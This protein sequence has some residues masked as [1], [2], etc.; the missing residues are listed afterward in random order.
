VI[1]E[2]LRKIEEL[3]TRVHAFAWLD[4]ER[5]R[6]AAAE[7]REGA[8]SGLL[9]GIKDIIDTAGIPTEHGSHLF[10]G[11]VPRRSATVVQ[12]IEAAGGIVAGKTVTAEMAYFTPGPTRNPWD[13][14]RTPGGSSM[15]SA[16]AVAAGMLDLAVGTQTNGSIIRP[17]A[18]CGTIGYKPS[19]G[20]VPRDGVMTFSESLDTV[21]GFATTVADAARLVA[22]MANRDLMPRPVVRPRLAVAVTP[23]WPECEPGVAE[24]FEAW[25]AELESRGALIERPQLPSGLAEAIPV[26]RVIMAVEGHRSLGPQVSRNP[27]AVS[28]RLRELLEEGA[29]IAHD[30]YREAIA[31]RERLVD[32]FTRWAQ[33]YDALLTL[34]ALGEAPPADTTG[35]PRLC[36]RWTLFGAPAVSVPAGRGPGGLPLGL[37]LVGAAATDERLLGAAAWTEAALGQQ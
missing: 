22:V 29:S 28:A 8:L 7:G 27:D 35:D 12:R 37:Q 20:I 26:H 34:P 13:Y 21:G 16:A 17:A 15:G 1:E 19:F 32:E 10:A 31:D 14:S 5:A 4:V 11:R 2:R 36:T 24:Q 3:E 23:E 9:V 18:F 33:P 6:E 30:R 25:V